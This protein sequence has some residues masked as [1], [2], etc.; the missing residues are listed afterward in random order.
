V[1]FDRE[2]ITLQTVR[3]C[4]QVFSAAFI[5]HVEAS[6]DDDA[7][8]NGLCTPVPHPDADVDWIAMTLAFNRNMLRWLDD[9]ELIRWLDASRLDMLGHLRP[10]LPSD[11]AAIETTLG[12][13]RMRL[14]A[15]NAK[16]EVLAGD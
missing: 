1:V 10:R 4:Q 7:L 2:R 3:G 11:P 5:G 9:P 16:L 12:P 13:I 15:V 14:K 6:C 8:K